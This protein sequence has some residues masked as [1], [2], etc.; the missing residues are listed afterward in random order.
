M[1]IGL[2]CCA[3]SAEAAEIT[4]IDWWGE[5]AQAEKLTAWFPSHRWPKSSTCS[6]LLIKGDI[7]AGDSI[8]LA[9]LLR[10]H[11]PF[12]RWLYCGSY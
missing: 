4:C 2:G 11:H 5:L 3:G 10:K 7:V 9:R 1:L 6:V 12:V 8:K